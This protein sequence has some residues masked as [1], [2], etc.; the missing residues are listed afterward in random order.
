MARREA[1]RLRVDVEYVH[2]DM[3][4][5]AWSEEFDCVIN[6]F[7]SFGYFED[8][9]LREVLRRAHRGLRPG[10]RLV[11]ELPNRDRLLSGLVPYWVEERDGDLMIDARRFEPLNGCI[12]TDRLIIR[13]GRKAQRA[14]HFARLFG[15]SELRDWL[16]DAGFVW[17]AW[18]RME[19][20]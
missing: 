8:D 9:G 17:P 5:I 6:W 12:M 20:P 7:T 1:E 14:P 11:I 4:A 16:L 15:Y 10:G 2:A 3:R 19:R 13:D 18:D